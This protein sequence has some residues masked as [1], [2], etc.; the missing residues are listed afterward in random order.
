VWCV[1]VAKLVC[2]SSASALRA[3]TGT[4]FARQ[5]CAAPDG[6]LTEE[7]AAMM[8][9]E[10][11]AMEYDVLIVGAGPAGLSAAIRLGSSRPR[12]G[13]RSFLTLEKLKNRAGPDSDF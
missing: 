2:S 11:E 6:G 9:A 12:H 10:R 4:P 7:E 1:V 13:V 8:G 3:R 5:L